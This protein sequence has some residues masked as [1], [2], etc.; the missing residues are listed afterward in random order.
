MVPSA[1]YVGSSEQLMQVNKAE[2]K[3]KFCDSLETANKHLRH[4]VHCP[5]S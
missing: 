2:M 5:C 3:I 1:G 4:N